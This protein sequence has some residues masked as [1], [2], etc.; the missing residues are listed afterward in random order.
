MALSLPQQ[1]FDF[2][3]KPEYYFDAYHLNAKGR[4]RFTETLVA[5]LVRQL[6]STGA[7]VQFRRSQMVVKQC[8]QSN[9]PN[10]LPMPSI[11]HVIQ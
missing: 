4:Q 5:E 8:S 1:T 2:L 3:E 7:G 10:S 6:G 9:K 11:S